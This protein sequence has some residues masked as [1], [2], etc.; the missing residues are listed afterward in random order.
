M[1]AVKHPEALGWKHPG[2][3]GI[4][5]RKG[6]ITEWPEVLGDMPTQAQV[7]QWE[8]QWLAFVNDPVNSPT[9]TDDVVR[10]LATAGVVLDINAA[11]RGRQ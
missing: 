3:G 4:R 7:Q 1:T 5:T 11:K 10:A 9:V 6:E 8:A 2:V